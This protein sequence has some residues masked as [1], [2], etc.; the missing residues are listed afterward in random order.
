MRRVK[1]TVAENVRKYTTYE[2]DI[3]DYLAAELSSEHPM[4]TCSD[5]LDTM[6]ERIDKITDTTDIESEEFSSADSSEFAYQVAD[7]CGV[8]DD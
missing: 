8:A 6:D 3:D 4:L 7:L 2:A 5:Y 1:I